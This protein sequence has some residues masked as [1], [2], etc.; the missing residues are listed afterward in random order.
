MTLMTLARRRV[1]L[2]WLLLILPALAVGTGAAWMLRRERMRIADQ[3]QKTAESRQEAVR[4]R[5]R[6]TG[7]GIETL[8][9]DVQNSLA[10]L[11]RE[12]PLGFEQGY[13]E[14]LRDS[15]A[16]VSDM[17]GA[18]GAGEILWGGRDDSILEW[19]SARPWTAEPRARVVE[20]ENTRIQYDVP[21]GD[22]EMIANRAFV[23]KG[24]C[25]EST[26]A[27]GRAKECQI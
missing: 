15:N 3:A 22:F 7:E 16:L 10:V 19:I 18:D 8:M 17:F 11:L 26:A 5:A 6:L 2:Y 9:A 1:L 23:E 13:L 20:S 12:T 25:S 24:K 21:E 14:E 4:E 27:G